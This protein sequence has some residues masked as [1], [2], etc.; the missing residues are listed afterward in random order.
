MLAWEG[1]VR[2]GLREASEG[3]LGGV[4]QSGQ[5]TPRK[6]SSNR[7]SGGLYGVMA[8]RQYK[9]SDGFSGVREGSGTGPGR[10]WEV[11]WKREPGGRPSAH[12][13]GEF[14]VILTKGVRGRARPSAHTFGELVRIL[15]KGVR[16]RGRPSAH[17]LG[18][19]VGILAEGMGVGVWGRFGATNVDVM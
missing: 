6:R 19:L 9:G 12:T 4:P 5:L 17:T 10:V 15:T 11:H 1:R 16:G 2:A 14:A 13:F 8:P 3:V 7:R 18:E